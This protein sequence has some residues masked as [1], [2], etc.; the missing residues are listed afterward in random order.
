M[1]KSWIAHKDHQNLE[2][3]RFTIRLVCLSCLC[4]IQNPRITNHESQCEVYN[5]EGE[6]GHTG[7]SYVLDCI[8]RG[9]RQSTNGQETPIQGGSQQTKGYTIWL[10]AVSHVSVTSRLTSPAA[11]WWRLR[12]HGFVGWVELSSVRVWSTERDSAS[13]CPML[14]TTYCCMA[15]QCW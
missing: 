3:V 15:D 8:R 2:Y 10:S 6:G 9:K 14:A 12:L 1:R 5:Q 13:M 7:E 11:S 4:Q